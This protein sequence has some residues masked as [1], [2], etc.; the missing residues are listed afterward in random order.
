METGLG[1]DARLG[2]GVD[3]LA[4][5]APQA[6]ALGYASLW[7]PSGGGAYDPIALCVRWH[8]A[9]GLRTGV[10]VL[11]IG[12]PREQARAAADAHERTAGGFVL[13][14]GSGGVRRGAVDALRSHVVA[15]RSALGDRGVP[16]YLAALGPRMLRLAGEIADGVALN[17]C[18]AEHVGWSRGRIGRPIPA[19]SYVRMYVDDDVAA[20]RL[21]LARQ[22]LAY[23][24][25]GNA[26]YRRHFARM[27]FESE[28]LALERRRGDGASGEELAAAV[29]VRLL[30]AVG[31]AGPPGGARAA[32]ERL[33]AGL[34]VAIVR[35]LAVRPDGAAVRAAM[36]APAPG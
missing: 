8:A 11:P 9:S 22:V 13:G 26:G 14:L 2:L 19:V 24:L 18:T 29:P 36:A 34:D 3:E 32:L 5:L 28:L 7:T 25:G 30:D 23:A 31:Y 21:A 15:V 10:S 16:L 20:A 1:L 33:G 12:E 27:G 6:A 17:W 35:L 4:A